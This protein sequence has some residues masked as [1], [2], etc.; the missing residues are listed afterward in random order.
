MYTFPLTQCNIFVICRTKKQGLTELLAYF[1]DLSDEE[2]QELY[3]NLNTT[4]E[5]FAEMFLH[6]YEKSAMNISYYS[7]S[8]HLLWYVPP[9]LIIIGTI[10]N[11]LSFLVLVREPMRKVSAY[12]YLSVLS[13]TDTLVLYFGLLTLWIGEISGNE[14]KNYNKWSCKTIIMLGYTATDYSVWLLIAVTVERYIAT[15]HVLRASTMCTTSRARKVIVAILFILIAINSHFFWTA[16]IKKRYSTLDPMCGAAEGYD[17]LVTNIWPWIDAIIYSFLPFL[18]IMTLNG[19]IINRVKVAKRGREGLSE[20]ASHTGKGLIS[21]P[22]RPAH[23]EGSARITFMLLIIS[24]TFLLTTLPVNITMIVQAIMGSTKDPVTLAKY[25]LAQTVTRLLMFT[26]HSIN[27]FLYLM[28]GQKFRQQLSM[29]LCGWLPKNI[30]WG[31]SVYS[32]VGRGRTYGG[33]N[34]AINRSQCAEMTV[35]TDDRISNYSS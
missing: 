33:Q 32:Q 3:K 6:D 18:I 12:N 8:Q 25:N 26:N 2:K 21:R 5:G 35:M 34:G 16:D 24:F 17:D 9:I 14:F 30:R 28:T 1:H 31:Q 23:H 19:L 15:V 10:G 7:A 11:L 20:S 27:F 29:L 13:I 22:C 4:E